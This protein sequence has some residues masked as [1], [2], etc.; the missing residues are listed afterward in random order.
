MSL[1]KYI[2]DT[3]AG[4]PEAADAINTLIPFLISRGEMAKA[5]EYVQGIPENSPQRA[6]AELRVGESLWRDYLIGMDQVRQW[7]REVQEPD[8]AKDELNANIARRKPE[9]EELKQNALSMLEAGV[10]RMRQS[11]T[12]DSTVPRAVLALAQIYVNLDQA[13]KAIALLDDEKI[14]V[15]PMVQ[16]KDAAIDVPELREHAYRVA[17]S[18]VVSALPKVTGGERT[19]GAN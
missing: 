16:R 9:L 8:A 4:S 10:E 19:G 5:R 12:I 2:V 17:L 11:G 3:W 14:G 6:S 15:F 18:A 13:P 1:A 7:E